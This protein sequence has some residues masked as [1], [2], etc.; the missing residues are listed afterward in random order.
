MVHLFPELVSEWNLRNSELEEWVASY[1]RLCQLVLQLQLAREQSSADTPAAKSVQEPSREAMF[2]K[3]VRNPWISTPHWTEDWLGFSVWGLQAMHTASAWLR[4]VKRETAAEETQEVGLSWIEIAISMSLLH[5]MWLPIKRQTDGGNWA[6]F[7]P[8]SVQHAL[9]SGVDLA[10]QTLAAFNLI[11]QF[12]ALTPEETWPSNCRSGKCSSLFMQGY[13]QWST[14]VNK[15]PQ[16]PYQS[17]VF[18]ILQRYLPQHHQQLSGLPDLTTDPGFAI[19]P[20]DVQSWRVPWSTRNKKLQSVMH[21]VRRRR[22][23]LAG[24]AS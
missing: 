24:Q 3:H 21:Q 15:R 13:W 23:E 10:E 7:Q 2:I 8:T 14:G 12:R 20:E 1:D 17:E 19:W 16:Y 9:S 22:I 18:T 5:G 4:Q 6:I 11:T